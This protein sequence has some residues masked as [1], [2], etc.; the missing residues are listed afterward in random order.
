MT[1]IR[2]G[3]DI[4]QRLKVKSLTFLFTDLKDL[5]EL[6]E[7]FGNL[8]AYDLVQEHFITLMAIV[9]A[10]TGAV[11]RTIGDAIMATFP[12][13]PGSRRRTA[14]ARSNDEPQPAAGS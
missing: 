13:P 5:T 6:Y 11:V 14:D 2:L 12:T 4:D 10:E 1:S 7:Q 8:V 9:S 3:L